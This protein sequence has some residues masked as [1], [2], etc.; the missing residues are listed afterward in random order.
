V[1]SDERATFFVDNDSYLICNRCKRQ[2]NRLFIYDG[3]GPRH[4]KGLCKECREELEALRMEERNMIEIEGTLSRIRDFDRNG[5]REK[6]FNRVPTNGITISLE[7]ELR[8]PEKK[9]FFDDLEPGQR[10][11]LVVEK[12]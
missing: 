4:G 8:G 7:C 6:G 10:I 9:E 12:L 5:D 1:K 11:R 3:E 2:V